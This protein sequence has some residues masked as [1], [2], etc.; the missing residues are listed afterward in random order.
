MKRN[1]ID[2]GGVWIDEKF[3]SKLPTLLV[4]AQSPAYFR[5]LERHPKMKEVFSVG[6][7]FVW[8]SPSGT[9]LIVDANDGQTTLSDEVIDR[10][11]VAAAAPEGKSKK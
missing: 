4:K 8:V 3:D 2:V 5:I 11:F 9:A 1:L 7:Y 10:L 6:N